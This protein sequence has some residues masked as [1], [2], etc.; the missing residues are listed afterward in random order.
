M[1][2]PTALPIPT[3]TVRFQGVFDFDKLYN[4][5]IAWMKARR[6]WVQETKYKHKVPSPLGAEQ[7]IGLSGER[8]V[9]E[10]YQYSV[11]IDFHLWDMQEV[12]IE[13]PDGT[14]KKL[15]NARM[16]I[17][18]SGAVDIDYEKRFESSTLWKNLKD[19][20][21]KYIMR[22]EVEGIWHDELYYRVVN[23]VDQVK[24]VLDMRAAGHEYKEYI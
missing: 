20:F 12:E 4:M 24:K 3:Q 16:E 21:L 18:F 13:Q 19:F 10:F 5:I 6:Y 2:Y 7:E 8:N 1:A 14:K 15:I 11:A 23:L 9:T 17:K 22:N